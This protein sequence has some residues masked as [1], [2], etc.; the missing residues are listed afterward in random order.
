MEKE[1]PSCLDSRILMNYG[2]LDVNAPDELLID[3][4]GYETRSRDQLRG[5]FNVL[6]L[7]TYFFLLFGWDL[8]A[9]RPRNVN[10]GTDDARLSPAFR[11]HWT[12]HEPE[13][14]LKTE[15][16]RNENSIELLTLIFLFLSLHLFACQRPDDML[17]RADD[18][19]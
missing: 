12:K 19:N 5:P 7:F 6:S 14:K 17:S 11:W 18:G 15:I 1:F 10:D 9:S 3:A 4:V 13:I 16:E 8:L 2:N